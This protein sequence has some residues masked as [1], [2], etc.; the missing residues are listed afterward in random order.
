MLHFNKEKLEVD[1]PEK[2]TMLNALMQGV[3]AN[4]PLIADIAKSSQTINLAQF[5]NKNEEY[6]N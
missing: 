6:I 5:M 4:R 2:K 1:S 3:N